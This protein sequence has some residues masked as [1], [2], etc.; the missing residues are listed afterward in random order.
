MRRSGIVPGFV[1]RLF[2]ITYEKIGR[3]RDRRDCCDQVAA[4][5]I[6]EQGYLMTVL[7]SRL[8]TASLLALALACV[9]LVWS[10]PGT[11]ASAQSQSAHRQRVPNIY[12]AQRQVETYFD[13]GR[14]DR[15]VAKVV[16]AARAW[17]DK[18]AKTATKPAIVLDIDETALSNRPQMRAN[19][20]ARVVNGPCDL[21]SGPCG[22]RAWQAM[23]QAKA[24]TP[25][26]A[27]AQ[28]AHQLGVAI[29]FITGRPER[30]RE[31]TERNLRE[32]GYQWASVILQPEGAPF[33]SA[34]DFKAPER[35]KIAEQGYTILL[36]LGDQESD[37]KGGYA[38]RTFK[39]PN[40]VYFVK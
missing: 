33:P 17:L 25:T 11:L 3:L 35:R 39:L 29:F 27:L 16:I 12:D 5:P 9:G 1:T 26:L 18:R 28:H 10:S 38:E 2:S 40:P 21:Q 30:L 20:W 22:L 4:T 6:L 36:N 14:Y 7:R 23:A 13:S 37:L 24:I 19:G 15:D 31:A 34:A 8:E 32:Q